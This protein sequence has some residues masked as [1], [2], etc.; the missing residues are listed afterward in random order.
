MKKPNTDSIIDATQNPL[1]ITYGWKYMFAKD[2][3]IEAKTPPIPTQTTCNI[4]K[5][6]D[7]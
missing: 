5:S 7:P 3:K 1:S 6:D 4:C 2:D